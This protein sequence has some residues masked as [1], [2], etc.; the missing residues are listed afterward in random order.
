MILLASAIMT[1]ISPGSY[2]LTSPG[3]T[4]QNPAM[5]ISNPRGAQ[6]PR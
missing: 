4:D 6:A 1:V 3:P 2:P 5:R